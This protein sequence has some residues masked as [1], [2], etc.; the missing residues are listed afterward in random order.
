MAKLAVIADDLTGANDT[1]VQFS[2]H[3]ISSCVQIEFE[4]ASGCDNAVDVVVIDTNSRDSSK[5]EAYGRVKTVCE[6]LRQESVEVVYKKIDSTLRGN[7]GAEISAAVDV[8]QP[9]LVV[10]APAFPR[11]HR[12]TVGGYHLLH[13]T[14][15]ELTEISRAPKSPVTESR[16]IELL[17]QQAEVEIALVPL[18]AVLAGVEA[19][20]Q[21]ISACLERGER[22]VVFD[23]TRDEHLQ[24]I[25]QA[26]KAYKNVLWVG[27]AGLAEQL[28]ALYQWSGRPQEAR[29]LRNGPVLVVAGSVSKTTQKQVDR[30][31]QEKKVC[32]VK[33]KV[34][35]LLDNGAQEKKRCLQAVQACLREGGEALLTSAVCDADVVE[36]VAAGACHGLSGFEVSEK[37][38]A[39]LGEIA[40]STADASLAGM[41]LTGG[42][43]AIHVCRSLGVRAIE[44]IEEVAVGIPLGRLI[45]GRCPGVPVITKAGAFGEDDSFLV[46]LR[47]LRKDASH[48]TIGA[49]D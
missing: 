34:P 26:A 15:I 5:E 31:L 35:A 28:P 6:F 48:T 39:A 2:K 12:S 19:V 7:L 4:P 38:A 33:M 46:A 14:P 13:N 10:I 24:T 8:L 37:T 41:I 11:N 32:L 45:G 42:D 3:D 40:A 18:H 44:I 20:K 29:Q 30:L 21:E 47:A 49:A 27:S 25:A 9:E 17:K 36:A 23:A 22:W 43:T 1:A 16:I